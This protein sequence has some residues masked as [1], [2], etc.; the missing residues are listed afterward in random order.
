[1]AIAEHGLIGD[2]QTVAFVATDGTAAWSEVRDRMYS[3][4]MERGWHPGR[5]AFVH[6][7]DADV[8]DASL[9]LMPL[10]KFIAPTDPRWASALDAMTAELAGMEATLS[11][12]SLLVGAGAH[13]SRAARRGAA[14]L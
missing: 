7:Y 6:H 1:V 10:C 14:R 13:S 11:M 9:L 5:R 3:Q 8:P 4:M 12:C 2:L